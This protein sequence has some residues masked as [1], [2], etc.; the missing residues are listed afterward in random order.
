M[1]LLRPTLVS[2][3]IVGLSAPSFAG[4]VQDSI[5]RAAQTQPKEQEQRPPQKIDK[6]YLVSGASLFV[7][8][9]SMAVYGFLHT[10][11]GEFVS[12]A[13]SK[14]SKT[15]LGAAGLAVAGAGGAILFLGARHA[16][17]APS[18]TV[19]PGGITVNKRIAW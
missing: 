19:G 13:V 4:D 2:L 12:G 15:G 14:E 5:A 3:V 16:K 11:G 17:H 7:V 6:A 18:V 8:G 9:M 1:K 10:S